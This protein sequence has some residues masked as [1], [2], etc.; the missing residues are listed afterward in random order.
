MCGGRDGPLPVDNRSRGLGRPGPGSDGDPAERPLVWSMP[1]PSSPIHPLC[2]PPDRIWPVNILVSP[3]RVSRVFVWR[4]PF[5]DVGEIERRHP[6]PSTSPIATRVA[7]EPVRVYPQD[8]IESHDQELQQSV[9]E[10]WELSHP[11]KTLWLF[12]MAPWPAVASPRASATV[13]ETIGQWQWEGAR[14]P[15]EKALSGRSHRWPPTARVALW[16][17]TV[18]CVRGSISPSPAKWESLVVDESVCGIGC[19]PG[20]REGEGEEAAFA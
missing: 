16:E 10:L 14:P 20:E 15:P 6:S 9:F 13:P 4:Y 17:G 18:L 8:E 19:S 7:E 2:Q 5:C 3:R 11:R 12:P 1:I